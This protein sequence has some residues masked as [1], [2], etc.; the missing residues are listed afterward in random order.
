M[1]SKFDQPVEDRGAGVFGPASDHNLAFNAVKGGDDPFTR[2]LREHAGR[3][4]GAE[5]DF[6]GA[7]VEPPESIVHRAD[8]A[9]ESAGVT[10]DQLAD[11][12]L[13][14]SA[15][16]S[17]VEINDGDL[18]DHGEAL[19]GFER[20][21]AFDGR[22]L[23]AHE[24]NRPASHEIDGWNDHR[25]TSTPSPASSALRLATVVWPS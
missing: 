14:G 5:D 19:G 24:L 8:A 16:E 3:G 10:P 11:Y 13:V 1:L 21:G 22:A 12:L 6:L 7:G 4:G 18:A 2:Q 20:V 25:R 15:P 9:A 23:A 17:G